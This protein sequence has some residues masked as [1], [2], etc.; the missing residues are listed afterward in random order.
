MELIHAFF[1]QY[2]N[3]TTAVKYGKISGSPDSYD[4]SENSSFTFH[5]DGSSMTIDDAGC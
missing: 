5:G 3:K 4:F 1:N 2:I